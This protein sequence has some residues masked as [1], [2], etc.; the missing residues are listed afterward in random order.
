MVG[1]EKGEIKLF[2][3]STGQLEARLLSHNG[4]IIHIEFD[5]SNNIFVSLGQDGS[6]HIQK[7]ISQKDKNKG[8]G[9]FVETKAENDEASNI[10]NNL[11]NLHK[12]QGK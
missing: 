1:N 6:I 9:G 12:K 11:R 5:Q 7:Q 10:S 3:I 2:C 8:S 4:S